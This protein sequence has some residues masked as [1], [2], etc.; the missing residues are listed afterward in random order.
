M[1]NLNRTI[2]EKIDSIRNDLESGSTTILKNSIQVILD[3][4]SQY[5]LDQAMLGEIV[6]ELI[7]AKPTMSA[8]KNVLSK[9]YNEVEAEGIGIL[10]DICNQMLEKI[11]T[12][13]QNTTRLASE[14]FRL[15]YIS[16]NKT[17][18]STSFS[19]AV[20]R[21]IEELSKTDNL[22]VV[23]VESKM[24]EFDYSFALVETC[25]KFG[26]ETLILSFS[27][28]ENLAYPIDFA[29]I[30]ADCVAKDVE[31]VNGTPSFLLAK[32]CQ[33]KKIPFYV[34]AESF[35]F[36]NKCLTEEG[37]D[38]IPWNYITDILSDSLFELW[39]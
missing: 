36:S 37:F 5:V 16:K 12:S 34:V 19:S 23:A 33:A 2:I 25:R 29:I 10:T 3:I 28:I 35:K 21:V 20:I 7:C 15:R 26:A 9:I 8:P 24:G 11:N 1:N 27:E 14:F 6:K 32:F 31:V 18:L 17:I 22:K 4:N 39:K 13:S 38:R 30:G